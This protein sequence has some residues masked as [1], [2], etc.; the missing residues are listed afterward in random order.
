MTERDIFFVVIDQT[1]PV[2][3]AAYLDEVCAGDVSLR[4]RVEALLRSHQA[5]GSFL[6][7]AADHPSLATVGSKKAL[8]LGPDDATAQFTPDA[9]DPS[10]RATENYRPGSPMVTIDHADSDLAPF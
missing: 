7:S 2:A 1:D 9:G 3:R 8:P 4:A 5:A 10:A 6:A